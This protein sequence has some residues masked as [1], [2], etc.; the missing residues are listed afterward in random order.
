M[1][2]PLLKVALPLGF[3]WLG[4]AQ[5]AAQTPAPSATPTP[6]P[7][8]IFIVEVTTTHSS[9]QTKIKLG[10]PQ[11]ITISIGYNNQPSFLP[12]GQ[13]IL[14]DVVLPPSGNGALELVA[15]ATG[16]TLWTAVF[17]VIQGSEW[18]PLGGTIAFSEGSGGI[19]LMAAAE[20][21]HNAPV[22][23][24]A[25]PNKPASTSTDPRWAPDASHLAYV[26]TVGGQSPAIYRMKPDGSAIVNLTADLPAAAKKWPYRWVSNNTAPAR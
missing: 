11:K 3:L 24:H 12:D 10:Q 8:N 14:C 22:K 4:L 26:E 2:K 9:T 20:S 23:I 18:S 25:A 13:S 16:A 1:K 5:V 21:G 15:E 7:G 6:P 17:D 19:W